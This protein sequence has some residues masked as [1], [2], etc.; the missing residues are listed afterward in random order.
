MKERF[1]IEHGTFPSKIL[2]KEHDNYNNFDR[3]ELLSTA[4]PEFPDRPNREF[5]DS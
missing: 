2:T 3:L 5:P 4:Y 1:A